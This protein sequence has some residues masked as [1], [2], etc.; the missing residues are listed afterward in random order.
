MAG[1]FDYDSCPRLG[2][3]GL[4]SLALRRQLVVLN[5]EEGSPKTEQER[6]IAGGG[7]FSNRSPW[8]HE[9][10]MVN[11]DTVFSWQRKAFR[12][13]SAGISRRDSG[14]DRSA[15]GGQHFNRADG[16]QSHLTRKD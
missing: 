14:S 12:I 7:R 4:E 1:N 5:E 15:F 16:A 8:R 10:H 2:D 3:L 9:L 13:Y 6:L 11:L